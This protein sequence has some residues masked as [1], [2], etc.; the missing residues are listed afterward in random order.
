MRASHAQLI[1]SLPGFHV[2]FLSVRSTVLHAMCRERLSHMLEC[3]FWGGRSSQRLSHCAHDVCVIRSLYHIE[4]HDA[5][6]VFTSFHTHSWCFVSHGGT[7]EIFAQAGYVVIADLSDP[8]LT[9]AEANS[10]FMYYYSSSNVCK[11]NN[12]L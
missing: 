10:I 12:A 1:V 8:L 9:S 7:Q 11:V 6:T 2:R 5:Y 4:R 3:T